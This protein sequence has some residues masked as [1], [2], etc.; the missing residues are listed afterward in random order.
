MLRYA[1]L[2]RGI[3]DNMLL[4]SM[5]IGFHSHEPAISLL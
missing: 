1:L 4:E 3:D 5:I 2:A